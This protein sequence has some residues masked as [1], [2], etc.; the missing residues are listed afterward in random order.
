MSKACLLLW[1]Q[2]VDNCFDTSVDESIEDFK[3][4]T[5]QRYRTIALWVPLWLLWL[6]DRR[7]EC[8]SP[9]LW[10][11]DLVHAGIEEVAEPRFERCGVSTLKKWNPLPET[12]LASGV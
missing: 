6:K 10:D 4:D 9:V 1:E 11:F 3:E 8:S 5:Q 12:F 7:Y 2:S